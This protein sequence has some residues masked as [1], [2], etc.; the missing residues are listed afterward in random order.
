MSPV[1][2]SIDMPCGFRILSNNRK[3]GLF[4]LEIM[5]L[6]CRGS[7]P[8]SLCISA[9]VLFL[10]LANRDSLYLKDSADMSAVFLFFAIIQ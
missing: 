9:N 7:T 10:A 5:S 1:N 4:P 8:A 2:R 3:V 6:V